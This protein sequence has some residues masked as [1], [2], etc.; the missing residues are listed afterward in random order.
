MIGVSLQT[1]YCFTALLFPTAGTWSEWST[2]GDSPREVLCGYVHRGCRYS[3]RVG[4]GNQSEPN[5]CSTIAES[6]MLVLVASGGSLLIIKML[7]KIFGLL[8]GDTE[9]PGK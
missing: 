4:P 5:F 1:P 7:L 8:L 2:A 6:W 3:H 9:V